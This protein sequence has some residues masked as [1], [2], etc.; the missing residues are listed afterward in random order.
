MTRAGHILAFAIIF[1]ALIDFLF[2][3]HVLGNTEELYRVIKCKNPNFDPKALLF[4]GCYCGPGGQGTPV[5]AYDKCCKAHD[6]CY[7]SF[8]VETGCK[9]YWPVLT[10]IDFDCNSHQDLTCRKYSPVFSS[11]EVFCIE[12][13]LKEILTRPFPLL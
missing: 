9:W 4:Y 12:M 13:Y 7:Q 10:S 8:E 1:S 2:K 11:L 5:D 3:C 6:D